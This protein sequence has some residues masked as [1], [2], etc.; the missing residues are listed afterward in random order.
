MRA[1]MQLRYEGKW[2]GDC[3]FATKVALACMNALYVIHIIHNIRLLLLRSRC[4]SLL[5][6]SGYYIDLCYPYY[7]T[8]MHRLYY[9]G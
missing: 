7:A 8:G 3:E 2:A 4:V 6:R 5:I 1:K 9:G